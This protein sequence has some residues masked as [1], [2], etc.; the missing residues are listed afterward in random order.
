MSAMVAAGVHMLLLLLLLLRSTVV[1]A[2]DYYGRNIVWGAVK[3]GR[4]PL[5]LDQTIVPP[6]WNVL[7]NFRYILDDQPLM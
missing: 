6:V 1:I 2:L 5:K 4:I 3:G 7:D